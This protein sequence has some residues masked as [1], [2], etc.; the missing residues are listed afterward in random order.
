MV[1]EYMIYGDLAELLRSTNG[2]PNLSGRSLRNSNTLHDQITMLDAV[3]FLFF[4]DFF[5]I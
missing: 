1:F 3:S 2:S 5:N 4:S